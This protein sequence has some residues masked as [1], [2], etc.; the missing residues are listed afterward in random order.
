MN[1]KVDSRKIQKGDTFLALRGVDNDGHNYISKAIE[2]GAS[3]IIAE[4]GTYDIPY[5]IVPDTRKYLMDYLKENYYEK[6]S[7][8][9]FIGITGTNGKTTT[10]FLIH[11]AL[12]KLGVKSA[13]IGTVGFYVDKKIRSLSNTTPDIYDLYEM[14]IECVDMGCK[15]VVQEVSSQGLSYKRVDG[16][17]FDYAIFTNLTQDHLDYH[18]TM[19]NYCLAKQELFRKLKNDGVAIVNYDDEYKNYFLLA[20]NKNITYGFLGGDYKI[21]NYK[22]TNQETLFSINYKNNNYDF[23]SPLFGKFNVYNMLVTIVVL[24]QIGFDLKIISELVKTL[25]APSGRMD[26][27]KYKNN[28]IIVDY[29]HTPDALSKIINTALEVTKGKVYTVFGCTGDRDRTKRPIMSSLACKLSD[30]V[31]MTHDDPHNEDQKQIFDDMLKG[32][33]YNNYEICYDRGEAIGKGIDMLNEN[34]TL[35]ILGKGHEEYIICKNEKIPFN[36]SKFVKEYIANN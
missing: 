24:N 22:M 15:Y 9:K 34:D 11:K 17:L 23:V 12:N 1:L 29:A 6:I 5:E 2:N 19:E 20:E 14:F 36:D 31:I 3:K 28:S 27:I 21:T 32:L 13:Y 4:E 18:K 10:A 30:Y 7:K 33:E 35:L 25:E 16:Y 8:L 26:L